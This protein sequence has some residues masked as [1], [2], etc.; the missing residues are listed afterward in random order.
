M[1]CNNYTV[2]CQ[3][4]CGRGS[5]GTRGMRTVPAAFV[6]ANSDRQSTLIMQHSLFRSQILN[7]E[8]GVSVRMGS[9]S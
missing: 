2:C 8:H 5:H 7:E 6:I 4:C 3:S 1:L 9:V